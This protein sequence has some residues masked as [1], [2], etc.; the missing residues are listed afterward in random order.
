MC[1]S[2][3]DSAE[4]LRPGL[5]DTPRPAGTPLGS[6]DLV[7]SRVADVRS[8]ERYPTGRGVWFGA[9]QRTARRL[10]PAFACAI[11]LLGAACTKSPDLSPNTLRLSQRNEPADLDP[12]KASLPDEFFIIRALSEGL[13]SPAPISSDTA[14]PDVAHS[15]VPAAAERWEISS[16]GLSYTFHLRRSARWSNGEPVIAQDFVDSYRRLLTPATA[17]PKVALFSQV[18]N[19]A[20]FGIG[21][22]SDFNEVGFRAVDSHTLV[23]TLARP[24]PTF[25]LYA[26]SGPWIPVNPRVVERFGRTWTTPKNFVGNGPFTLVEWRP[27][28]RITVRKNPDYHA[29]ETVK[30]TEIQF[31]AFDNGDTEDRAYRAGQIDV[32]MAVPVTKLEQYAR[33]RSTELHRASLAE[34]RYLSFNTARPPLNDPRVRHALSLAIDRESIAKNVL[35]G[36]QQPTV[37]FVPPHLFGSPPSLPTVRTADV[38]TAYETARR[39]LAE[40]G[41][42]GGRNFPQLELSTWPATPIVEAVQ[43]M[44]Q[45]ELGISARVVTR[46][47]KVH[48]AALR[49][50]Q[51]DIGYITT[52]IDVPDAANLLADFK[53]GAAGNYPRWSDANYDAL[54]QTAETAASADQQRTLLASAEARLLE[55]AVVAPL[56]FNSRNWLMSLRVHNWQH[57]ALWTRFYLNVEL[58]SPSHRSP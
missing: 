43:A 32:T 4:G 53:S 42:P 25:L 6:G 40:A 12:A 35:R 16:D 21:T 34:T 57:D 27:H 9:S 14:S 31:V 11:V 10:L 20:A 52:I 47:A 30:L 7:N 54:L 49:D 17:A 18:K 1:G 56:F 36:G 33:E 45:K 44:W 15:V 38:N 39:L 23:V 22:I 51:Y 37:R 2:R 13:V 8:G 55:E 50:G 29:A 28:Q 46:E 3:R 19:A 48:L 24:S 5:A 26:A 58:A 41:F